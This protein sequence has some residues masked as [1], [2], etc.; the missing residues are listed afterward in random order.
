MGWH[1]VQHKGASIVDGTGA[2]AWTDADGD[3]TA[4]TRGL[5]AEADN[6]GL[7][8]RSGL[9]CSWHRAD[10]RAER[11]RRLHW[12]QHTSEWRCRSGRAHHRGR[13]GCSWHRADIRSIWRCGWCMA[14]GELDR[15]RYALG[16]DAH[17]DEHR[18]GNGD[19]LRGRMQM[20]VAQG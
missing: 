5:D 6:R 10:F 15:A 12:A 1:H 14:Q 20:L 18:E 16:E 11:R 19:S 3:G 17:A 8:H 7:T 13:C 2:T 9:G 4:L